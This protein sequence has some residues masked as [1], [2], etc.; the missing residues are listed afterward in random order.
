MPELLAGPVTTEALTAG[1]SPLVTGTIDRAAA[2]WGNARIAC[3]AGNNG[4]AP[5]WHSRLLDTGP[6]GLPI[7]SAGKI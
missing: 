1:S 3:Q 7:V 4:H 5:T 6:S 2:N